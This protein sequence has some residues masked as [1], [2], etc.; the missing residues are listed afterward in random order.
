MCGIAGFTGQPNVT[1]LKRM[2]QSIE[3]RGPDED[4]FFENP[5]VSMSMR[6]LSIVDLETG[7]QPAYNEDRNIVTVFNGEIYN[8]ESLRN[9]L[10]SLGHIFRS[11][12]SDTEVIVHL[13]EELGYEWPARTNS[14]FGTA[15]WDNNRKEVILYRDRLGKK[16]LY[17]AI[18]NGQ[19]VFGSEIKALLLHPDVSSELDYTALYSY[20]GLKN[21]SAPRTAYKDI[22]QLL[23]GQGLI[24]KDSREKIFQWWKPDF[25]PFSEEPSEE[26]ASTKIRD[27]LEDAIKL[28]MNC[29]V[30][31]GAY[32]SGGVDSSSVVALMSRMQE[33]PVKTFCLG[34]EDEPNGQFNGK[35]QDIHFAREMSNRLGTEHHE[36]IIN[37]EVLAREMPSILG[38]FDE[39]FSGTISTFFLSTLIHKYVKVALSGD[40]ADELFSSYLAHRLAYPIQL[41]MKLK[42]EGRNQP[43]ALA[44]EERDILGPYAK[45]DQ[46]NFLAGLADES[47]AVWRDKL[48]V[49]TRKERAELL[50]KEFLAE[51]MDKDDVYS[52]I[53]DDFTTKDYLNQVMETDQRELLPNQIL[54]F[55]DRLSMAHSIEVRC[56]FLDYRLV[57]YVNRLSGN[58]KINQGINKRILK[59]AIADLLPQKLIHRPKEGFVQPIYTWMHAGLKDW[60][61]SHLHNLPKEFFNVEYTD[62]LID[63]FKK[64]NTMINA[65]IWNLVCFGI[66]FKGKAL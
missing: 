53:E 45:G 10:E 47:H 36:L 64:E 27:L 3:H 49:F 20:F 35:A 52:A 61:L 62:C 4:G 15:I 37:S 43:E 34:Y 44:P 11:K 24:W 31:Y 33:K 28:R 42:G 1:I 26:E 2:C 18:K 54:P 30:P 56:P 8:H 65:K 51:V 21:T 40:G 58:F 50:S 9:E 25:T 38:S 16:P 39:P 59:L 60:M 63:E 29:N 55:V 22:R 23:P 66:W 48:G 6:R 13:Y 12:H 14:M 46:F 41:Y 7:G 57:E 5:H 17:Y 19:L 32:L